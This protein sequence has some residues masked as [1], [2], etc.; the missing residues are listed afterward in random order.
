M[1]KIPCT[2]FGGGGKI[3]HIKNK[4]KGKV[5]CDSIQIKL[6]FQEILRHRLWKTEK[7][8]GSKNT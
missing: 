1:D 2:P 7:A 3:T 6:K 4:Y 8:S 5:I